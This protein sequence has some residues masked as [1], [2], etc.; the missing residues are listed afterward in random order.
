MILQPKMCLLNVRNTYFGCSYSTQEGEYIRHGMAFPQ[1]D[2]SLRTNC[3][4]RNKVD[5]EY[6]KGDIPLEF[7]PIDIVNGLCLDY[8]LLLCTGIANGFI[9]LWMKEKKI[10]D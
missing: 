4:F 8:M 2:A 6:Y 7:L 1:L 3:S 5:E 10:L 9:P